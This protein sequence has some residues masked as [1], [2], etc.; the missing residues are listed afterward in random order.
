MKT[1]AMFVVLAMGITGCSAMNP[2]IDASDPD[3]GVIGSSIL[4]P[5]AVIR[6]IVDI[7][8]ASLTTFWANVAE[9]GKGRTGDT[10]VHGG[11]DSRSGTGVGA[12]IDITYPA[13]WTFSAIFGTVD[14][15]VCRS[16]YP[17]PVEGV[18]PWKE[19]KEKWWSQYFFPN[20]RALWSKHPR[21]KK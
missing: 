8:F 7:P 6:D 2:K 9:S 13:G 11:W 17:C 1:L 10:D 19:E 21:E 5:I 18:S 3:L 4:T 16:L 14:Y 12:G 15:I 20:T